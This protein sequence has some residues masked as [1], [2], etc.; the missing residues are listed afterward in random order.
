MQAGNWNQAHPPRS[1]STCGWL[2][3]AQSA[4]DSRDGVWSLEDRNCRRYQAKERWQLGAAQLQPGR[5][6]GREVGEVR[7]W[8][9][10]WPWQAAECMTGHLNA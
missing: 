8:A 3:A 4:T 6:G 1:Q 10:G 2:P 5:L 7:V 9:P